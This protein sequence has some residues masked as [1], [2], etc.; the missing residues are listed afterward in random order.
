M[1]DQLQMVETIEPLWVCP[2]DA[3]GRELPAVPAHVVGWGQAV[4]W[5]VVMVDAVKDLGRDVPLEQVHAKAMETP[6]LYWT[7]TGDVDALHAVG[8]LP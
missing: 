2:M 1:S 7:L 6:L 4:K 8:A 3:L 5:A